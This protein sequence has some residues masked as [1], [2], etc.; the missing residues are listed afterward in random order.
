[1]II[2][3]RG[4]V[5]RANIRAFISR[6]VAQPASEKFYSFGTAISW[7]A[8]SSIGNSRLARL[9]IIMP[10]VGYLIVFNSTLSEYFSTILPADLGQDADGL[11]TFLYSRNLYFL[12]FGLLLF[13][14]GVALFNIVAPSQ[15]R[16]F[17][18]TESYIAA[19]NAIK[20]P[21]LIIG[22]FESII[23]CIFPASTAK[24]GVLCLMPEELRFPQM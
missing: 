22:S 6:W 12:Y 23:V 10:F 24:S 14:A 7:S 3:L 15:I 18:A 5:L 20:T 4:I 9:T 16:R 11:L 2:G 21:N 13:G 8:L 1:M 17:P 19:M